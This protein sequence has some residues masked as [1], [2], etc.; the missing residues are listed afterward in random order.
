MATPGWALRSVSKS[1]DAMARQ[2]VASI[3]VT[4][5]I[6]GRPSSSDNSPKNSPGPSSATV[7]PSR[8]TLARPPAM[9]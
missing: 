1:H 9:R 8:T 4:D 2:V 7:A 5:A 3:A 6:R